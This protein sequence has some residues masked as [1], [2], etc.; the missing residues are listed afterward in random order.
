ME[1]ALLGNA[2]LFVLGF[3]LEMG[4][5]TSND[6][7]ESSS[8]QSS[9]T[10]GNTA[11][12]I[13]ENEPESQ[14]DVSLFQNI[15]YGT[16]ATDDLRLTDTSG[17][18]AL[19]TYEGDDIVSGSNVEDWIE[20]DGGNDK[21]VANDGDDTVFGGTGDDLLYG[22]IGDDYVFGGDGNDTIEGNTGNDIVSGGAGNDTV[23]GGGGLDTIFGGAGNDLLTSD[24]ADASADYS[25]GF[26]DQL[27][28]E[29]GDDRLIFTNGD[30]VLGGDGTDTFQMVLTPTSDQMAVL[31]D[32]DQ[33]VDRLQIL[34]TPIQ[35]ADG[36]D[37]EPVLS[38]SIDGENNVTTVY[39]DGTPVAAVAGILTNAD[40]I[41]LVVYSDALYTG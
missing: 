29:D 8:D 15:S 39:F 10:D 17:A 24:R 11:A 6:D 38:F 31:S 27:N 40:Q 20:G 9:V 37:I 36:T 2:A 3:V 28:G 19:F 21:I 34:Y 33:N 5:F 18:N 25:R 30:T 13:A 14:F 23:S 16:D 7:D 35:D 26:G 32:Y 4:W 12:D 22:M 41:D 1:L